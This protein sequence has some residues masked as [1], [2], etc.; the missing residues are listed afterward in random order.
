MRAATHA[1]GSN[2]HGLFYSL[3]ESMDFKA[4]WK[5]HFDGKEH[6]QTASPTAESF[7]VSAQ[8]GSGV[9]RAALR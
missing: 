8:K 4:S 7:G 3:P 9:V 5:D 1:V 6:V 2:F